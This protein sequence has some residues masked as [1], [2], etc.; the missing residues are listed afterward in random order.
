MY[1]EKISSKNSDKIDRLTLKI[2]SP[3]LFSQHL[4]PAL[5][6]F[7][8]YKFLLDLEIEKLFLNLESFWKA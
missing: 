1:F 6:D 2:N 3:K 4:R 7:S 5:N 8:S